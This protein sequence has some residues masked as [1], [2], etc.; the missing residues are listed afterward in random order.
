M[1]KIPAEKM[2]FLLRH[3]A[4][5]QRNKRKEVDRFNKNLLTA[6]W[7]SLDEDHLPGDM[8]SPMEPDFS[9]EEAN[10]LRTCFEMVHRNTV[11]WIEGAFDG[12]QHYE[13]EDFMEIQ[14]NCQI[15]KK[16]YRR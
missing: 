4:E 8:R 13:E 3:I 12:W 5:I 7:Q 16:H 11:R 10:G 9:P 2:E 14:K 15:L 6:F 1:A